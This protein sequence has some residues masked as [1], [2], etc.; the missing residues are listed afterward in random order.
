MTDIEVLRDMVNVEMLPKEVDA[1]LSALD[2][3]ERL[4]GENGRMR[5]ALR[6]TRDG[7]SW[8]CEA[9]YSDQSHVL[10]ALADAALAEPKEA[11]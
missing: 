4:R 2:E 10:V 7:L 11:T 3:L 8:M 9:V 1:L 6:R 5:E